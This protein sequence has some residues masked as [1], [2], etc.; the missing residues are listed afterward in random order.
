[1]VVPAI[2]YIPYYKF[3]IPAIFVVNSLLTYLLGSTISSVFPQELGL[4]PENL[5]P[6]GG[7]AVAQQLAQKLSAKAVPSDEV[8]RN[9]WKKQLVVKSVGWSVGLRSSYFFECWRFSLSNRPHFRMKGLVFNIWRIWPTPT[10]HPEV[11]RPTFLTGV[12]G[13]ESEICPTQQYKTWEDCAEN[14]L[15]TSHK[16]LKFTSIE[17]V[18]D[19]RILRWAGL[20]SG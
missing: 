1:M 10:L 20:M 9:F 14:I 5:S 6:E 7:A 12:S 19:G 15:G 4:K 2:L 3:Y 13:I 17:V 18:R 11:V 8:V 16:W